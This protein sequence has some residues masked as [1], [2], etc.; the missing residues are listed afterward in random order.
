MLFIHRI[1]D[2]IRGK[3]FPCSEK[4]VAIS[5]LKKLD[6]KHN[7]VSYHCPWGKL[8]HFMSIV[9]VIAKLYCYYM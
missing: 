6:R 5:L 1:S 3:K 7:Y 2:I 9:F 4:V 8:K